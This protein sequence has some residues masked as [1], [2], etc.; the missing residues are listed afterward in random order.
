[1]LTD[2]VVKV[3]VFVVIVVLIGACVCYVK[4]LYEDGYKAA[5]TSGRCVGHCL[6]FFFF[7]VVLVSTTMGNTHTH[8]HTHPCTLQ[9]EQF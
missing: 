8:T 3:C 7:T 9:V 4:C 6:D 1:M 5:V 2:A